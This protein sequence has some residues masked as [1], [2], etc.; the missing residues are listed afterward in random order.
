MPLAIVEAMFSGRPVV[1]T[2]VGGIAELVK[3]GLTG[4]LAEAAVEECLSRALE[5][6]WVQR[7]RLQ[8]MGNLAATSIREF[9]PDD[10]IGIFAKK[11]RGL[12]SLQR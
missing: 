1:A 11:L 6:V 10:P 12:A 8:E 2:N 7:E 9:I 3:D 4:F 5:R